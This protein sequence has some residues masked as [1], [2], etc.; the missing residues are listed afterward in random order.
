MAYQ[1]LESGHWSRYTDLIPLTEPGE[2]LADLP[3]SCPL[4]N[5]EAGVEQGNSAEKCTGTTVTSIQ[6]A[7]PTQVATESSSAA[8]CDGNSDVNQAVV[9]GR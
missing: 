9:G 4:D 1:G 6:I 5:R 8:P 2:I 3:R 7:S